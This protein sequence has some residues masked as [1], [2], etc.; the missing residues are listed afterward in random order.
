MTS[1][2]DPSPF[3]ELPADM[4]CDVRSQ[5]KQDLFV[6]NHLCGKR[7]G[8][9]VEF[10]ASDGKS[11]S[12]TWL[13]E[14]RFGWKGILAEPSH[15]WHD[16]L[17]S[18]RSCSVD[19]RCVWQT[20]GLRL[21]FNETQD[22]FLSSPNNPASPIASTYEVETVTLFDLLDCH[23]SPP[24]IDYLS[25]DTEGSELDIIRRFEEDEGFERYRFGA[26]T[27]EHNF[28]PSRSQAILAIL[29]RYGYQR[30]H[31]KFSAFDDWYVTR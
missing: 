3:A 19:T 4:E 17:R 24:L 28:N 12:N 1:L 13:L 8:Y 22:Q 5:I 6:L 30:I 29:D 9:F 7:N 26:I 27:I 14:K 11:L 21:P 20:T 18:N 25:M 2:N 31:E 23:S 15:H 10:E 16:S